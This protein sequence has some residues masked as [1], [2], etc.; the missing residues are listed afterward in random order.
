MMSMPKYL[1]A[2]IAYLLIIFGISLIVIINVVTWVLFI[3]WAVQV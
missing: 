1:G 2:L 3:K